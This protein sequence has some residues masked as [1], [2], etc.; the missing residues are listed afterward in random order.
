MTQYDVVVIG[1]GPGGLAAAAAARKAGAGQVVL[2][3]REAEAG[4]ILKQCIHDGFGLFRYG[5]E[6]TGPEYAVRIKREAE[7]AGVRILYGHHVTKVGADRTITV[8]AENGIKSIQ[9]KAVIAAT[10]CRERTRGAISIPG[11]RPAGIY[12][13]G[14]A[15]NLMNIHNVMAGKKIVILGSGDIGLIMA[16]RFMLEGADVRCVV[17]IRKEPCGLARNVSQ[18]LFDFDIPLFVSHTVSKIIGEKRLQAVEITEVDEHMSLIPDTAQIIEC[19]TLVLSVGLIPE[20]EILKYT[21]IVLNE[22]NSVPTD[23]FLQTEISGIFSCGNSRH[24]MDLADYVSRQGEAA[25]RNAVHF[26]RGEK[27]EEWDDRVTNCMEKGFPKKDTITCTICPNGCQI[28]YARPDGR[29]SGSR[30]VRGE[31]FAL[32]E[33]NNPKR[34]ITSTVRIEGSGHQALG[35]KLVPIRTAQKVKKERLLHVMGQIKEIRLEKAVHAGDI[36]AAVTDGEEKID[37][38]ATATV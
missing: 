26:I 30:C 38:I 7:N 21:G 20:N 15:Q 6:L 25:G 13:A 10:G 33:K 36:V 1:G 2:M 8:H 9:A 16:R 24:V 27:M 18:C 19:D 22:N 17:E 4:G 29:V 37:V 12:T 5:E 28:K 31:A 11:S 23:R 32:A 3:E 14:A 35:H 34:T